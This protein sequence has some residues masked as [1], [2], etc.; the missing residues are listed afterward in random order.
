M[1]IKGLWECPKCGRKLR[2]TR[3]DRRDEFCD[4]DPCN[5]LSTSTL[6]PDVEG[7][8]VPK[9]S[10]GKGIHGPWFNHMRLVASQ[11]AVHTQQ[12]GPI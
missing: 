7:R 8:D 9:C 6:N 10:C 1:V 5:I 11:E 4:F 2:V 12:T 3:D